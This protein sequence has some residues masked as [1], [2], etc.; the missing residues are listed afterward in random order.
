VYGY[1]DCF[2]TV[3]A[4]RLVEPPWGAPD[5]GELC[6]LPAQV[7]QGLDSLQTT[8][9][10][11]TWPTEFTRE[12][13]VESHTLTWQFTVTN[14]GSIPVPYLHVMH[15]LMPPAGVSAVQLP[16]CRQVYNEI[17]NA[18]LD[19]N[20]PASLAERLLAS[21]QGTAHMWLLQ[22]V[23]E[24][25]A[26]IVFRPAMRLTIR[27]PADRFPTLGIWWNR[28][29]Y[30]GDADSRRDEFALEPI[31]GPY[32]SLARC[33]AAG[34]APRLGPGAVAS[35]KIIWKVEDLTPG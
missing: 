13:C 22:G 3:D 2:P 31:P 18:P 24:G 15:S 28:H 35:W 10:C 23:E 21:P 34:Q 14:G 33:V 12:L 11:G 25:V 27:F 20:A 6:W 7:S 1:D 30:P 17:A 5:H 9:V 4:C 16:A 32:G 29:G 19:T 26:H 8:W